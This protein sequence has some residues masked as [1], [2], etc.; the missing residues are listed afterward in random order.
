MRRRPWLV[1]GAD[2]MLAADLLTALE[3][4]GTETVTLG[5]A[6][7]DITDADAVRAAV[8]THRPSVL[9]NCAA[10]TAVDAAE[11]HE[12]DAL[13]VNA[14]G[15]RRLAAACADSGVRLLQ[16]S[17]DYVFPGDGS[18]P[19]GEG[20]PTGPR[21]A[22][23]RTKR[24][25]ERAVLETLPS[26]GYVV[27]TAWLYGA[28]GHNFVST[29]IGLERRRK[30]VD[31]VDDQRGQPT[32]TVDLAAQ[33]VRLGRAAERDAAPPGVY[34]GTGSGD[35]TWYGLARET[36][37]LLGADP[38][39]VRPTDSGAL[40]RAARRPAY[41]VLGHDRWRGAGLRPMRHWRE[42]LFHAVPGLAA[43]HEAARPA[44]ATSRV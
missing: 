9:V 1:T 38:E 13:A 25:G 31:V 23:G 19:Y 11:E 39:R 30:T 32:W 42:A 21:T 36:F 43:A 24:E 14:Q 26:L 33:L 5:R 22:Y 4:T 35:T 15:P 28:R 3:A 16:P 27:R 7:L 18:A 37:R 40:S 20:D 29:M 12:A 2:G 44:P 17:T 41:S 6:A 34:H 8:R 10:W